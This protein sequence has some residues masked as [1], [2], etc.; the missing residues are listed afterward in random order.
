MRNKLRKAIRLLNDKLAREYFICIGP[1]RWGS[2][3]PDLGI[4]I[5][6]PEIK[7]PRALVELSGS[8]YGLSP[9]PSFGT[10]FFQDLL[11]S[12]IYPLAICLDDNDVIFNRD[13]FYRTPNALTGTLPN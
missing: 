5:S 10:H 9:E 2:F 8:E 11:K 12:Q 4:D 1:G 6:Y 3:N 7:N 13:F